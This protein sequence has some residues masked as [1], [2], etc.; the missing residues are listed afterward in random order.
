MDLP[1]IRCQGCGK[2]LDWDEYKRLRGLME[3]GKALDEMDVIKLC[4]RVA[5]YS[6][7]I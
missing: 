2:V 5:M 7:P 1:P 4:C 3:P 6:Y